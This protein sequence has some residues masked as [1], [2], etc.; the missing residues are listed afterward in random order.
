MRWIELEGAV[1][2]R[3]VGGLPAAD[4]LRT[5][6]GR[7]LRGDNLQDL[8]AADISLLVGTL[9]V[10]TVVDLRTPFEVQALGPGPLSRVAS[11]AHVNHSMMPEAG[12]AT[13]AAAALLLTSRDTARQRFPADT[14]CGWYLGYLEDRPDQVVAALRSVS[15]T[16]GTALVHCAAGKDRTGV[17][18]ALA[19]SVAGVLPEEIAA[20]YAA[21]AQRTPAILARL[22]ASPI[23]AADLGDGPDEEHKPRAATMTAFLQQVD[24]RYGG[25]LSFLAGHGFG[26]DEA[27]ALRARLLGLPA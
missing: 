19:L 27:A 6:E 25:P 9:G 16:A 14:V 8:S 12:T 17:I 4:G 18:V 3:D 21:T 11:V 20:D 23:Y 13:D 7:L 26:A 10:S 2:V 1:N 22:R 24:A 15:A 5:A